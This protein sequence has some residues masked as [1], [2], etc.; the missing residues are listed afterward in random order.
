MCVDVPKQQQVIVTAEINS[1]LKVQR[2]YCCNSLVGTVFSGFSTSP[3]S[4]GR[5]GLT[6]IILQW[7][8]YGISRK[9]MK[10]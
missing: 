1:A 6:D 7:L 10:L 9:Q 2:L 3:V 4:A 5:C 8:P